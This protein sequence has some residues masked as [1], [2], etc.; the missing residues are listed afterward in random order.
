[1]KQRLLVFNASIEVL[2]RVFIS[3]I[4]SQFNCQKLRLLESILSRTRNFDGTDKYSLFKT[5]LNL[6]FR[7]IQPVMNIYIMLLK[8][9]N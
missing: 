4:H 7:T 5:L 9:F 6:F 1:M 2:K 8:A 3:L